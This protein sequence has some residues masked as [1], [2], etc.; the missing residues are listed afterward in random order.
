V[1]LTEEWA[2]C[3]ERSYSKYYYYIA[4]YYYV[5]QIKDDELGGGCSTHGTIEKSYGILVRKF[6]VKRLFVET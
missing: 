4:K 6:E 5:Y 1:D 3:I 2:D